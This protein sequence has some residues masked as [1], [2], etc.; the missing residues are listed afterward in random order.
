MNTTDL[1]FLF[2][3]IKEFMHSWIYLETP[4]FL[5][6]TKIY[7]L[8]ADFIADAANDIIYKYI[9]HIFNKISFRSFP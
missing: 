8:T 5:R 9:T 1:F 2:Q 4:E 7:A 3:M 6:M